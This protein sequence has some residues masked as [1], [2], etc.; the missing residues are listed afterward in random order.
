MENIKN[1]LLVKLKID[2]KTLSIGQSEQHVKHTGGSNGCSS[3]PS[4]H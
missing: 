1:E 3:T 2:T 4:C